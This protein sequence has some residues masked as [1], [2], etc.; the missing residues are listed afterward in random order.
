MKKIITLFLI[1]II[2]YSC[3]F[4]NLNL[5]DNFKI[6]EININNIGRETFILKNE[7]MNYSSNSSNTELKLDLRIKSSEEIKD[8]DITNTVTKYNI[9][10]EIQLKMEDLSRNKLYN[11]TFSKTAEYAAANNFSDTLQN[12]K[13]VKEDSIL[14]LSE[15]ILQFITNQLN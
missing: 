12:K 10:V 15:D 7:I 9:I 2:F 5:A 6:R 8:K 14:K 4:K 3:G 1:S 13:K 11:R